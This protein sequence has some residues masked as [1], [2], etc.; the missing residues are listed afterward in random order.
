[1]SVTVLACC[2]HAG[3]VAL[4]SP[5]LRTGHDGEHGMLEL[6]PLV[7]GVFLAQA[8]PGPNMIAVTAIALGSGRRAGICTAAG[9]ATGAFVWAVLFT[10]GVSALLSAFPQW[11]IA[12]KLLGGGYLLFLGIKALR[13]ARR[14]SKHG[15]G[16]AG[17][18]RTGRQ[19]YATGLL[20]VL[21]NPK[22]ALMWA[23]VA[24]FLATASFY[25]SQSQLV[26]FFRSMSA[27]AIYGAYARLF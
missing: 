10:S 14:G 5:N 19:A 4:P 23:A 18:T 11:L 7:L 6:L 9:V 24:M 3:K 21:T 8:L 1:M 26:G 12:M 22:A 25:H 13:V 15:E 27:V 2:G 20:V 16:A 17:V